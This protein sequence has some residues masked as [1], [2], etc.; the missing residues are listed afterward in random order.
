MK[1]I[2]VF[3]WLLFFFGLAWAAS[4]R[5][6]TAVINGEKTK[7]IRVYSYSNSDYFS[8]KQIADALGAHIS[9]HPITGKASLEMNNS[10]LDVF[11][12]T[13]KYTVKEKR[14]NSDKIFV[15]GTG[16]VY[17]PATFLMSADFTSFSESNIMWNPD[18]ML[19][20]L[21]KKNSVYAT[22]YY[23]KD[24]ETQVVVECE[25]DL[26]YQ[27]DPSKPKKI[28]LTF[29]RGRVNP[30]KLDIGD[31]AV[32]SIETK[33][34]GRSAVV[35]INLG[36]AAGLFSKQFSK[37]LSRI[38][39]SVPRQSGA[40]VVKEPLIEVSSSS[41]TAHAAISSQ[42]VSAVMPVT[43]P[44]R[45]RKLIVLDAGHG[46]EDPGAVGRN[47]TKEKDINLAIIKELKKLF[48]EEGTYDTVLTREDDT[49]IP[50]VERT[51]KANEKKADLFVA[52]HCNASDN[53]NTGGFEIYFLNE[54]ASDPEAAATAML[55]N[56]VVNMEKKV[57]KK[58]SRLQEL[59]WSMVVNEYI[60][61]SSEL[62]SFV[63]SEVTK[64]IKL[65]NRGVKQAGFFVLRGAQMPAVL[66]ECAF[67]SHLGEESRL[68]T[69]KFQ[70]LMADSIFSGIIDFERR[71]EAKADKA[72]K[73]RRE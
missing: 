15:S 36:T 45:K 26:D 37:D 29:L 3:G 14:K 44:S 57:S 41:E 51:N 66:V 42:T 70:N 4:S 10:R 71:Q 39:I 6:G 23:L 48:D 24:D 68:R 27:I 11:M 61:E 34:S 1:K 35:T 59:L 30:E 19:L 17:L 28:V 64:R 50:L 62:C 22:R 65:E 31:D 13:A 21:D 49:F 18:S 47:G 54:N 60:N 53:K 55:E 63:G 46:G 8:A 40:P 32:K 56:S 5:I 12:K 16:D 43:V 69:K 7:N 33:N 25:K 20:T 58:N 9:M 52:L 38:I 72:S 73:K 2:L 67:I